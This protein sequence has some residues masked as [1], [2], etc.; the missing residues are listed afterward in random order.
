MSKCIQIFFH[1]EAEPWLYRHTQKTIFAGGYP[2][3]LFDDIPAYHLMA[4]H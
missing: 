3:L 1:A 2:A 4:D